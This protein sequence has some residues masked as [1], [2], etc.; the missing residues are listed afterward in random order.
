MKSITRFLTLAEWDQLYRQH[1]PWLVKLLNY[2]SGN[3]H[4][5]EDISQD[6]FV[7]VMVSAT[8][9]TRQTLL[10]NPRFFLRAIAKN[11][12]IAR[13]RR[14]I[15]EESYR[16][17]LSHFSDEASSYNI[18]DHISAIEDLTLLSKVLSNCEQKAKQ[19]FML[20]YLENKTQAEIATITGTSQSSVK[21]HLASCLMQYYQQHYD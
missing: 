18:E 8:A 15:I 9:A 17:A 12:L 10:D 3:P 4:I 6:T 7:K 11:L 1:R 13:I 14:H 19:T 2:Q 5:A 16:E 21:R 20:Y